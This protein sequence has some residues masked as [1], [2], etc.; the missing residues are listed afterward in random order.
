[1]QLAIIAVYKSIF[2]GQV[3]FA[4]V[5]STWEKCAGLPR[6]NT[7]SPTLDQTLRSLFLLLLLL[8]IHAPAEAMN[9]EKRISENIKSSNILQGLL[10]AGS[11]TSLSAPPSQLAA[12]R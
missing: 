3:N 11:M 6:S 5:V 12:S 10:I 1:M 7:S 2:E 8:A 4:L 9:V